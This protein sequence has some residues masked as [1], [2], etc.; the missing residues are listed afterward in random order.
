MRT[1]PMNST[2]LCIA[3]RR[4]K[5]G[6]VTPR[7]TQAKATVA[8]VYHFLPHYRAGIFLTLLESTKYNYV[9]VAGHNNLAPSVPEWD[10]P[11]H[12]HVVDAGCKWIHRPWFYQRGLAVL[13]LRKDISAIIYLGTPHS[14]STWYSAILARLTGKQVLFWTHGWISKKGWVHDA[15]KKLF[16]GL[17]DILLLYGQRAKII[18][19]GMGIPADKLLVIHNSLDYV[20][21][22]TLRDLI[23]D[24]DL[25][26][27][28]ARL[29]GDSNTPYVIC[30]ARLT[31][32]C[33]LGLLL[34]AMSL[35]RSDHKIVNALLVGDGPEREALETQARTE[36]LPVVFVGACYDEKTVAPLIRAAN[37]TVSPGKIGLTAIHSLTYGT[38]VIT[39]DDAARQGPEVEAIV[40]DVNGD[41]F[42]RGNA[43]E[44]ARLIW[45]W[46]SRTWPDPAQRALCY[47]V[48]ERHY[49]PASQAQVI[50]FALSR[51]WRKR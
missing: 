6:Q 23:H 50:E 45:K 28:R 12:L 41:L 2:S 47:E 43:H 26:A 27:L 13:A 14:V 48:I 7:L 37:V 35:L 40:P 34:S 38:P 4:S 51:P 20:R 39:H 29:F 24:S 36:A 1:P 9:F 44:L 46:C 33:D 11:E 17:A 22:K 18:G 3:G 19:E 8:I 15:V 25:I 49:N 10:V 21:Q 32:E 16:M 30:T 42:Q 5:Q 31:R